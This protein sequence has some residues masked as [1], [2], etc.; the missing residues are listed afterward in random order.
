MDFKS[1]SHEVL[2]LKP[3]EQ[4]QLLET[5]ARNLNRPDPKIEK[6]WAEEAERRVDALEAG[7]LK[8]V[9]FEEIVKRYKIDS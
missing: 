3:S 6:I 8:T 1:I 4:L 9:P 5:I 7:K 2:K